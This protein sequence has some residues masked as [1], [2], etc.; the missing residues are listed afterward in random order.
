MSDQFFQTAPAPYKSSKGRYLNIN[1][2]TLI[3]EDTTNFCYRLFLNNKEKGSN[4]IEYMCAGSRDFARF[5]DF[6]ERNHNKSKIGT[7]HDYGMLG[8]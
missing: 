3:E 1:K 5:V 2:V 6:I 7:S 4:N 8:L